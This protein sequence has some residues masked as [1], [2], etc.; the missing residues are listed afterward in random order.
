MERNH[1]PGHFA[2]NNIPVVPAT[3]IAN[4]KFSADI[5][6]A[7]VGL[8]YL[9]VRSLDSKGLWSV[10]AYDTFRVNGVVPVTLI[11]FNALAEKS[12]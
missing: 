10:N 11:S 12:M 5:S 1:D 3:D 4:K 8:H 9:Y 6:S 7:T 2:A